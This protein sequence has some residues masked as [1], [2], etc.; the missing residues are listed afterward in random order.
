LPGLANAIPSSISAT[1][2][3]GAFMNLFI[4]QE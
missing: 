4:G 1:K 2:F 3:S